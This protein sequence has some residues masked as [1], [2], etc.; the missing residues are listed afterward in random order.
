MK[1]QDL[2]V[3]LEI[4]DKVAGAGN[5]SGK[6][7]MNIIWHKMDN[8]PVIQAQIFYNG[9][10]PDAKTFFKP[11]LDLEPAQN[12]PKIVPLTE[13]SFYIPPTGTR[14]HIAGASVMAPFDA[15]FFAE[16]WD[17]F[18]GFVCEEEAQNCLMG[19]EI[20]NSAPMLRKRQTETAFTN[21]GTLAYILITPKWKKNEKDDRSIKWAL[22]VRDRAR[23]ELKRRKAS[24]D[25]DETTKLAIGGYANSDGRLF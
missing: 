24:E 5:S 4:G 22:D 14:S 7:G 12:T 25:V 3:N 9:S 11:L 6:A 1:R 17:M 2:D 16:L 8:S 23:A 18:V 13:S 21:R 10:E 19:F 15:S 20:P